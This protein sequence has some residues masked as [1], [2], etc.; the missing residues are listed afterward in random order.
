MTRLPK[1]VVKDMLNNMS[2]FIYLADFVVLKT[3]KAI[4]TTTHIH[5]PFL[6]IASTLIKWGNGMTELSFTNITLEL[7]IFDLQRQPLGIYAIATSTL[8]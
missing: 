2:E 5:S 3:K 7:N 1:G 4:N 8:N 6:T